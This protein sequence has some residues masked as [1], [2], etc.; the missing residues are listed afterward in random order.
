MDVKSKSMVW[1][2]TGK[3]FIWELLN[4]HFNQIGIERLKNKTA[5]IKKVKKLSFL[6]NKLLIKFSK[7]LS[8]FEM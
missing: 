8:A 6:S 7:Y 2:L 5:H 3:S 1:I 4:Q